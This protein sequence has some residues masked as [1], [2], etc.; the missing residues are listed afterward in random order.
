MLPLTARISDKTSSNEKRHGSDDCVFNSGQCQ[1]F[2]PSR[3]GHASSRPF[4]RLEAS[5][6]MIENLGGIGLSHSTKPC[7]LFCQRAGDG[8]GTEALSGR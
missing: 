6:Q 5:Q 1:C 8:D 2:N 4:P 3:R 7:R